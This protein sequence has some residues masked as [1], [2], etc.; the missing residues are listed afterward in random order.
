[1][2]SLRV[3]ALTLICLIAILG[4]V[5][6][7]AYLGGSR[8]PVEHTAS[9]TGTIDAPPARV[10]ARIADIAIAPTWRPAVKAVQILPPDNGRDHWIE[11]LGHGNTMTF[12]AMRTEPPLSPA[13]T[14]RREV[15]LDVPGAAYG[16]TWTYEVRPGPASNTT[17]LTITEAG[18]IHPPIYR[19]MMV[20]VIGPTHNLDEYLKNLR[21]V[22]PQL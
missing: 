5:G 22:T 14:G 16:G 7:I 21:A 17:S 18:F 2:K 1:M 6:G 9:V 12:L 10:F 11:D 15:L 19:F 8:L 4:I 3:I 20:H 13:Q